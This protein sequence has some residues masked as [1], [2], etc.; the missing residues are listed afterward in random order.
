MMASVSEDPS[1]GRYRLYI[2]RSY[3]GITVGEQTVEF[4]SNETQIYG[5]TFGGLATGTELDWT[6]FVLTY[7]RQVGARYTLV[8]RDG[9]LCDDD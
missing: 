5:P 7:M 2:N 9:V 3:N 4:L 8:S 6:R 1:N